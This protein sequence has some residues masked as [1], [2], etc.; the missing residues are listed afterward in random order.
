MSNEL[1]FN[2]EA[3][4][5]EA[6]VGESLQSR[7]Q[8]IKVAVIEKNGEKVVSVQKW[9]RKDPEAH[10]NEGKGFHL[11]QDEAELIGNLIA[12]ATGKL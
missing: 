3:V 7:T 8:S 2:D 9:W 6:V 1:K 12:E 4:K 5:L 11:K 10:W